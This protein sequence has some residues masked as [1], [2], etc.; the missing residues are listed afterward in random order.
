MPLPLQA[1][2]TM[3]ISGLFSRLMGRSGCGLI[4]SVLD[5]S[6]LL[7]SLLLHVLNSPYSERKQGRIISPG[8]TPIPLLCPAQFPS[9]HTYCL[10]HCQSE[11]E[12]QKGH[13][14]E[15]MTLVLNLVS[16]SGFEP[17]SPP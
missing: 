1:H 15:K 13:L 2:Y 4:G 5:L 10:I 14:P 7:R 3:F 9:C 16:R 8:L 11:N 6:G 12:K 17:L